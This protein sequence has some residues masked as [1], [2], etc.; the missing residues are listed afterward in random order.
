MKNLLPCLHCDFRQLGTNGLMLL[1]MNFTPIVTSKYQL[2]LFVSALDIKHFTL[3]R[4][5]AEEQGCK[6][7]QLVEMGLV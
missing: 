6:P 3:Y 1:S 7:D 2:T 4:Q 5:G